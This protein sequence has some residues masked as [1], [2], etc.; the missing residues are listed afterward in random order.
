MRLT[1]EQCWRIK[2][3]IGRFFSG[4]QALREKNN[5]NNNEIRD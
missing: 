4:I 1:V 3:I 2:V 5:N